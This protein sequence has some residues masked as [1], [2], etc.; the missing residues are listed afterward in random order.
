MWTQLLQKQNT[1]IHDNFFLR[2]SFSAFPR[3]ITTNPSFTKQWA[4]TVLI[5]CLLSIMKRAL[6]NVIICIKSKTTSGL[7]DTK[8]H[9]LWV[10]RICSKLSVQVPEVL[11]NSFTLF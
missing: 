7:I 5:A 9:I 1:Y 10:T 3:C 11:N 2:A 6:K 8:E 4:V